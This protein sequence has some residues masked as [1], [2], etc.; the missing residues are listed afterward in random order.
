[1][2]G[3]VLSASLGCIIQGQGQEEPKVAAAEKTLKVLCWE[4]FIDPDLVDKFEKSYRCKVALTTFKSNEELFTRLDAGR[5]RYDVCTPSSY[6][7]PLLEAERFIMP[8]E[9]SSLSF[10]Q[11]DAVIGERVLG[12]ALSS[13]A[14]S[15]S[16][17]VTGIAYHTNNNPQP[18]RSWHSLGQPAHRNRCTLL[19]DMRELLG[20]ALVS[21]GKSINSSDPADLI[22]AVETAAEWIKNARVLGSGGH[23]FALIAGEDLIAQSYN[24]DVWIASRADP[25]LRFF[26]PDEGGLISV[27][28]L[29]LCSAGSQN[30]LAHEFINFLCDPGHAQQN[31]LWS[32]YASLNPNV[33]SFWETQNINNDPSHKDLIM[34]SEVL[35]TVDQAKW[36]AAWQNLIEN[37]SHE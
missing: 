5:S 20:A 27:D 14:I 30:E 24:G 28:Q 12:K 31:M 13:H 3:S 18:V 37:T 2:L 1:M 7:T 17:S 26:I 9:W 6:M 19:D 34:R 10:S 11:N 32:G 8:L 15:F 4:R 33:E 22:V 23:T 25:A 36:E 21:R 35:S 29:C 16:W